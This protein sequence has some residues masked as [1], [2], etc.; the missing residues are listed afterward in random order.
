MNIHRI[1]E[2]LESLVRDGCDVEQA[3]N[4]NEIAIVV[5]P[6]A[7]DSDILP[8]RTMLV[9]R[10]FGPWTQLVFQ[11]AGGTSERY[12]VR[13]RP[14]GSPPPEPKLRGGTQIHRL[15]E[16]AIPAY[17]SNAAVSARIISW[18]LRQWEHMPSARDRLRS[19]RDEWLF[20]MGDHETEFV[21]EIDGLVDGA[22]ARCGSPIEELFLAAVTLDGCLPFLWRW[23]VTGTLCGRFYARLYDDHPLEDVAELHSQYSDEGFRIDFAI[24]SKSRRVAVELDGHDF[25]ERTR[26]QASNDRARDRKLQLAGWTVFRFTGS[27]VWKDPAACVKQ[28]LEPFAT[29]GD[30]E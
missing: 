5:P 29:G 16:L 6:D 23:D 25:H 27:D 26:E 30:P 9:T 8:V 13:K 15:A 17:G 7:S 28:C 1:A 20:L 14:L 19:I 3:P 22:F 11:T 24:I 21:R 18:K 12:R 4:A 10:A 2:F